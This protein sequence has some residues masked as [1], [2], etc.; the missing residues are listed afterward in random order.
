MNYPYDSSIYS[1]LY[2][3]VY[4]QPN[5]TV[6]LCYTYNFFGGSSSTYDQSNFQENYGNL[7]DNRNLNVLDINLSLARAEEQSN[8]DQTV[9][10]LSDDQ[11]K[12]DDAGL[13]YSSEVGTREDYIEQ[14]DFSNDES[15]N[16]EIQRC[17]TTLLVTGRIERQH[18]I[19]ALNNFEMFDRL[20]ANE[21][22]FGSDD[23]LAEN[24]IFTSKSALNWIIC[25]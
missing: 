6:P 22:R 14:S 24:R 16:E 3:S 8:I 10:E 5:P 7:A 25:D 9:I 18:P 23:E 15:K 21:S 11:D 17:N 19:K 1:H 2:P 20:S 12:Q 4:Q 13:Y